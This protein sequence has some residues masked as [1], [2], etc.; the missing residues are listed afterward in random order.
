MMTLHRLSLRTR[1]SYRGCSP[2]P[3]GYRVSARVL[4]PR[5]SCRNAFISDRWTGP[6]SRSVIEYLIA[7]SAVFG[8]LCALFL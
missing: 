3:L 8:I 7:T 1:T 4:S 2:P 5:N 6:A